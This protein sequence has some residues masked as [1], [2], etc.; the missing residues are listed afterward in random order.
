MG[1]VYRATDEHLGIPVA[2]KENLFLTDEYSRQFQR[3]ARILASMRHPGLPHVADYFILEAQGQYLV[4][5]YI[6]G[7]R[8]AP[9]PGTHRPTPRARGDPDRHFR[10]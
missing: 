9:A 6:E 10:V 4:M 2:V 8:S 7:R 1:A 3:E 5:D